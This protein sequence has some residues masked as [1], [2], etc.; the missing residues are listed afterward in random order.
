MSSYLPNIP[1]LIA[2]TPNSNQDSALKVFNFPIFSY[3][4]AGM[5]VFTLLMVILTTFILAII[6]INDK[7]DGVTG[8]KRRR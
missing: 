6:T 5:P 4:L 2:Y 8:G 1:T 7:S 3:N